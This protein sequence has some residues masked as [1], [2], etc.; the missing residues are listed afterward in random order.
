M[1]TAFAIALSQVRPEDYESI[2]GSAHRRFG[3]TAVIIMGIVGLW[4]LVLAVFRKEPGRAYAV[5]A[6]L[7]IPDAA[8]AP[9]RISGPVSQI[10]II[11]RPNHWGVEIHGIVEQDLGLDAAI[12]DQL[13]RESSRRAY[14]VHCRL[15]PD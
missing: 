8:F 15:I 3:W 6:A 4:G 7:A 14:Q 11:R 1:P 5:G 9:G 13:E 12:G 10:A 2:I